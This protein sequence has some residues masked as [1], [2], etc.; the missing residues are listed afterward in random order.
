MAYTF[1]RM[2]ARTRYPMGRRP[3]RALLASALMAAGVCSWAAKLESPDL[4]LLQEQNRIKQESEVKIQRDI[5][6]PV[7]GE[8]RAR[9]FVDV[10]MEVKIEREESKRS[11][12]GLAERYKEK[13]GQQ[14]GGGADTLYVLP[15]IPKPKTIAQGG[16]S[17]NKPESL[18]ARQ[19]EQTKGI[20]ETRFAIKPVF[21]RM[22]VKVFHDDT[23]LV[24]EPQK[25]AVR[26]RVVDAMGQYQLAPDQVVFRPMKINKEKEA[27]LNWIERLKKDVLNPWVWLPLL[28]AILFL[29]L[30]TFLFGPLA[31][32]FRQYVQA[33]RE[34]P[35][36]EV[37]VE[38]KIEPPEEAKKEEDE[39]LSEG[40][41]DITLQ[42]KP[43][44]PPPE[45]DESMKKFE[46][47]S[48]INEDNIKRLVYMFLLNKTD[49][50]MIA[51][52][53]SYLRPEFARAL[54]TAL[55][56]EFQAKVALEALTVRQVTR[57]QVQ[58]IDAEVK[59]KV[60]FVVGG[61][62][63][64][65]AMLDEADTATRNNI[66]NYLKND[67]PSLYERVR[68]YILVFDD[69][70]TF[71]DRDMQTI[72]RELKPENMARALQNAPPELVNKF[73][74]N[75]S[76]GAGTLL[77]EA[78]EYTSGLTQDKVEEERSKIIEMVK[79]LD[80]EGK[81]AVRSKVDEGM[82]FEALQEELAA[83]ERREPRSMGSSPVG[84]GQAPAAAQ[85]AGQAAAPAAAPAPAADAAQAQSYFQAGV[86][87]HDAG[88][89]ES[90]VQY[91]EYAL[92]LDPSLWQAHQYLGNIKY[93]L[94]RT[95]EALA[96]YEKLL[97]LHPD[98]Q[99]KQ[100]VESFKSQVG[101]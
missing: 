39:G 75:M 76:G 63:R 15:G 59:E 67:K 95:A 92:T 40:A 68:K 56:V 81:I 46:P 48:Y 79:V 64:L 98:P 84:A 11:G 4:G 25:K 89:L 8:G 1:V 42:R 32:F 54:L 2:A 96:H 12:L 52:V 93:Q 90:G 27:V 44:E 72:V 7:L 6:D 51:V 97:E 94:G 28:Y 24:N 73:F 30:L 50:W 53:A 65:V 17:E 74:S 18:L 16:G 20:E 101:K 38:S 55:P 29:L 36:A 19:S 5:L 70:V 23:V 35:A 83:R 71:P 9:V 45:E 43:P 14:K 77:R 99:M 60:D 61:I 21:K 49:P 10:E 33:L 91:L 85:S 86:S 34:K 22:E 78:M 87:Y 41:L 62:E 88:Q 47:F 3:S 57:E 69:V 66:L 58:A 80:K 100:W 37:N 13:L 82:G 31:K 26:D